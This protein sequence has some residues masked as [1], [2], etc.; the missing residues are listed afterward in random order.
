MRRN[1]QIH[2]YVE[3]PFLEKLKEESKITGIPLAELCRQKI[4]ASPGIIDKLE[5]LIERLEKIK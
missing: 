5:I 2:F 1:A 4:K 3:T